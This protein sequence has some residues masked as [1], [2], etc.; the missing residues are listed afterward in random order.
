MPTSL[1]L[2]VGWFVLHA[3]DTASFPDLDAGADHVAV[4]PGGVFLIY[5]EHHLGAK[6]WIS[7]HRLT[8][9]GR[10]SDR[11]ARVRSEARRC[12]RSTDAG[13]RLQRHRPG[14]VGADRRSHD[15]DVEQAGG[16][17]RARSAR[18]SGLV[19]SAAA[20]AGQRCGVCPARTPADAGA[21][22]R[23]R[24]D[25]AL[26][27]MAASAARQRRLSV[28]LVV[29]AFATVSCASGPG[30]ADA[31]VDHRPG[32]SL[33]APTTIDAQHD[34][35]D[36]AR[37][38]RPFDRGAQRSIQ[39]RSRRSRTGCST[40][41]PPT[42][43]A[44]RL[45]RSAIPPT[46]IRAVAPQSAKE[47]STSRASRRAANTSRRISAARTSS[48]SRSH[49]TTR[50]ALSP[51]R[52][53]TTRSIL[54]GPAGDDGRPTVL[55]DKAISV[56]QKQ[57]LYFDGAEW[58][59]GEAATVQ[60]LGDGNQCPP[61]TQTLPAPARRRESDATSC[62]DS[63]RSW[64]VRRSTPPTIECAR[65]PPRPE[66]ASSCVRHSSRCRRRDRQRG[67]ST[68]PGCGRHHRRTP[69]VRRSPL[70]PAAKSASST[71]RWPDLRPTVVNLTTGMPPTLP[72]TL[73][74][75]RSNVN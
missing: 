20:A 65:H 34:S 26:N 56:R 43:P 44:V 46:S 11:L 75:E 39:Q 17:A 14:C 33:T 19:V 22:C 51:S 28:A 9:D 4:G 2:P 18:P 1:D 8:I 15:A 50:P 68:T 24:A 21:D 59:V 70:A 54:L 37:P 69:Q 27:R 55:N 38:Q 52:V 25:H 5:L 45:L 57:A 40:S 62:A 64:R 48:P 29:V 63:R 12:E 41:S 74:F 6:V 61:R 10:D 3:A 36:T 16:G 13:N 31:P 60:D 49:S 71:R 42:W 73:P 58:Q 67:S 30:S 35:G 66:H 47:R 7:E 32:R 72:A 23:R 53:G